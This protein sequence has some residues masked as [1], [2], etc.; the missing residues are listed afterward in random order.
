MSKTYSEFK[1]Y[2]PNLWDKIKIE[3]SG[4]AFLIFLFLSI[5][6]SEYRWRLFFTALFWLFLAIIN[7]IVIN[8]R[9]RILKEKKLN[10]EEKNGN[11]KQI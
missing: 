8:E 10:L 3:V 6:I 4:I 7:S 5:W 2:K 11:K 9:E 1:Y